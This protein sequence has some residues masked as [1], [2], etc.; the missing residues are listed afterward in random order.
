MAFILI[1]SRYKEI[2][3]MNKIV[4]IICT[5]A[6]TLF[7]VACQQ[8]T[9]FTPETVNSTRC[10]TPATMVTGA[11]TISTLPKE[12]TTVAEDRYH[13]YLSDLLPEKNKENEAYVKLAEPIWDY[14]NEDVKFEEKIAW[15]QSVQ[16]SLAAGFDSHVGASGL[17]EGQKADSM[18]QILK[19][20]LTDSEDYT[21]YGMVITENVKT[22]FANYNQISVYDKLLRKS[23]DYSVEITKWLAFKNDVGNFISTCICLDYYGGTMVGPC[24][25]AAESRLNEARLKS[26]IGMLENGSNEGANVEEAKKELLET[27]QLHAKYLLTDLNKRMASETNEDDDEPKVTVQEKAYLSKLN[28][29]LQKIPNS[30]DEWLKTRKSK[31]L[32]HNTV[33]LLKVITLLSAPEDN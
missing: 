14:P 17:D 33:E 18:A 8:V 25:A 31:S 24:L 23:P 29:S 13:E 26:T 15:L 2:Q 3:I 22:A 12:D 21:T 4:R 11:D 9:T 27:I 28:N 7:G 10:D 19:R 6:A 32:D 20:F 5:F 16:K 30:L 1:I